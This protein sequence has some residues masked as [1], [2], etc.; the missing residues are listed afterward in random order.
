MQDAAAVS[1]DQFSE[2]LARLPAGLDLDSLALETKA[3][4]RR[5]ELVDGSS[6]LRLAQVRGP[7]G[8]SLRQTAGWASLL[9]IAEPA[10]RP[11]ITA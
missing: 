8:F 10:I 7:G 9:D 2:L 4:Q 5:R 6:L 3:I 11:F 1:R